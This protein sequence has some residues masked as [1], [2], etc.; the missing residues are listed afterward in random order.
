EKTYRKSKANCMYQSQDGNFSFGLTNKNKRHKVFQVQSFDDSLAISINDKFRNAI[1]IGDTLTKFMNKKK[2]LVEIFK[3]G[4]K[5]YIQKIGK[6]VKHYIVDDD[7]IILGN[8]YKITQNQ[9]GDMI[10][11]LLIGKKSDK[12]LYTIVRDSAS[13]FIYDDKYYGKKLTFGSDQ[14]N[15][16]ESNEMDFGFRGV[17]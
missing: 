7:S 10:Q 9:R 17:N 16:H 6:K 3:D 5:S 8:T 2:V 14:F 12:L 13:M 1:V 11:I 4:E 15:V